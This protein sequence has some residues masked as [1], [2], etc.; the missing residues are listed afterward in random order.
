MAKLSDMIGPHL[1]RAILM[2][3]PLVGRTVVVRLDTG[4]EGEEED[5][6]YPPTQEV[7]FRVEQQ[8]HRELVGA[9]NA[10]TEALKILADVLR[11]LMDKIEART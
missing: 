4:K 1:M 8:Q 5:V 3:E 10:H 11:E 2:G 6:N 9:I 7:R